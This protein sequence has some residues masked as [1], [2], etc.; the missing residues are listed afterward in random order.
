VQELMDTLKQVNQ[1]IQK[2]ARLRGIVIL[3]WLSQYLFWKIMNSSVA[4]TDR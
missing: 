2:A 3:A 4:E 1:I